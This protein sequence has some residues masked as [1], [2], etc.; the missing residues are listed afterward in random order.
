MFRSTLEP[1]DLPAALR[2]AM[3]RV[4]VRPPYGGH[5]RVAIYGLLEARM[6]RADLVICGGLN[7]GVWPPSPSTDPL[8]APAV[9]RALRRAGGRLPHRSCRA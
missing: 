8:L 6:T 9:L 3:D 2:D 1:A 7:E 5:P 4:A